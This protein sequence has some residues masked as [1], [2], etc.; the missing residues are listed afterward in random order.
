M[1]SA[2]K[3]SGYRQQHSSDIFIFQMNVWFCK[4]DEY[5]TEKMY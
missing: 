4:G 5:R 3:R 1:L 2:K